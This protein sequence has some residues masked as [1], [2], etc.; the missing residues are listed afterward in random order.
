M[1]KV[2]FLLLFSAIFLPATSRD[3]TLVSPDGAIKATI[4]DNLDYV[5][6][7]NGKDVFTGSAALRLEN[8]RNMGIAR[9]PEAK[10]G[11]AHCC[12]LSTATHS[13]QTSTINSLSIRTKIGKLSSAP[14]STE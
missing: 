6:T 1:K 7:F 10:S 9:S 14:T 11:D 5:V 4:S 12:R 13:L 8:G 3:H 2:I